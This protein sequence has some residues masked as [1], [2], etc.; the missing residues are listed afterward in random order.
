MNNKLIRA[1]IKIKKKYQQFNLNPMFVMKSEINY[2]LTSQNNPKYPSDHD[3]KSTKVYT[4]KATV[5]G[6]L[7]QVYL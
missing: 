7:Y 4:T 5:K 3:L 1:N 6:R 2:F